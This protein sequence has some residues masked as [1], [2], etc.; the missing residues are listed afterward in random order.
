M[1]ER[2]PEFPYVVSGPMP[3]KAG[4]SKSSW[5]QTEKRLDAPQLRKASEQSRRRAERFQA[6]L[7]AHS[8][9]GNR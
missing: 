9:K 8:N 4:P 7:K 2:K 1:A 6:N 3:A 5:E